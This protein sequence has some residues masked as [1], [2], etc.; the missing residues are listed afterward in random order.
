[1]RLRSVVFAAVA[2]LAFGA[3]ASE[4]NSGPAPRSAAKVTLAPEDLALLARVIEEVGNEYVEPRTGHELLLTAVKRMVSALDPYSG[5]IEN[6]SRAGLRDAMRGEF[7]GIGVELEIRDDLPTVISTLPDSP[8]RAAALRN[9]DRIE[10]IDGQPVKGRSLDEVIGL[11]KGPERSTV[12]LT[13]L[14]RGETVASDLALERRLVRFRTV[15]LEL[16]DDFTV[17]RVHEFL[18][19]TARELLDQF[20]RQ[21]LERL[22]HGVVLDLRGN[23]GGVVDAAVEM[24]SLFLPPQVL[25]MTVE[26]RPGTRPQPRLTA[27]P[28]PVLA[29]AASPRA[30]LVRLLAEVPLTV[31]VDSQTA[32]SAEIVAAALQAHRRARVIGCEHS[33]GKGS[34]QSI[35]QIT[36]G[37]ALKMTTARYR[38]PDGRSLDGAGVLPD[39]T[40]AAAPSAC[41]ADPALALAAARSELGR[42]RELARSAGPRA[43]S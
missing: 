20:A 39:V 1:M 30:R 13:L 19:L 25:V 2:G 9:G 33:M 17:V 8:A 11:V 37:Y 42:Q 34:I 4:Q 43:G 40:V 18:D 14:R 5:L 22:Q 29:D 21:P 36:P 7:A 10:R 28:Y 3:L 15:E 12:V 38:T 23:P 27:P 32:S 31:L 35:I 16:A 26:G 41:A 6:V 24:A